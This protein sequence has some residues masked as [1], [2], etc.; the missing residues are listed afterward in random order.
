MHSLPSVV[1]LIMRCVSLLVHGEV[2]RRKHLLKQSRHRRIM[3]H[4]A[5][6]VVAAAVLMVT[7]SHLSVS[8]AMLEF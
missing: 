4:S 8:M 5:Y 6:Q 2:T 3:R 7:V 1:V